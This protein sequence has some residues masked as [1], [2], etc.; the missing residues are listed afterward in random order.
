MTEVWFIRHGQSI[1]NAGFATASSAEVTL[2]PLGEQQA[3]Q[4]AGAFTQAPDLI[5]TSK[6]IRAIQTA[7]F[8][9]ERFP[10]VP[11]ENWDMHEFSYLS[12]EVMGGGSTTIDQRRPFSREYWDRYDPAYIH[13][14]G[15]ESFAQMIGRIET[16]QAQIRASR[17]K[18]IAIFGHGMFGKAILWANLLG[19][20]D[21]T[22]EYMRSFHLFIKSFEIPNGSIIKANYSVDEVRFGS[23]M[24]THLIS[25]PQALN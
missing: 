25:H 16:M 17:A 3:R 13:G 23:I 7:Q 11:V 14:P 20:F 2:T 12:P 22:S 4:A 5:I 19:S 10:G 21:A 9:I 24:R 18:F 8:T 6:Y 1:A 15:A